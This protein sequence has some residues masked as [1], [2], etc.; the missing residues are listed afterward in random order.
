[1]KK[2]VYYATMHQVKRAGQ[3]IVNI[4]HTLTDRSY[5]FENARLQASIQQLS[6]AISNSGKLL[7]DFPRLDASVI[8]GEEGKVIYF[9]PDDSVKLN[10]LE[11]LFPHGFQDSKLTRVALWNLR[12]A[13]QQWLPETDLVVCHVSRLFPGTV[14]APIAFDN[15]IRIHQVVPLRSSLDE[16]LKGRTIRKKLN[17]HLRQDHRGWLSN[18]QNDF[19]HFYY[20]MYLPSAQRRFGPKCVV[21]PYESLLSWFRRGALLSVSLDGETVAG[22]LIQPQN[23]IWFDRYS[24]FL[25]GKPE[26]LQLG[27]SVILYWYS[28]MLAIEHGARQANFIDSNAWCSDG[29][30]EHKRSWGAVVQEDPYTIGKL[31][32]RAEKLSPTWQEKLNKIG[33]L[34]QTEQGFLYVYH[35]EDHHAPNDIHARLERAAH[36]GLQGVRLIS[37]NGYADLLIDKHNSPEALPA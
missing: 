24:G 1:M 9:G 17:R 19:D 36:M 31:L 10:V 15:P 8:S 6:M 30:F 13:M 4:G 20:R 14:P 3:G 7:V 26:I 29:V 28:L 16:L 18:A 11:T 2:H 35:Q 27:V 34:T 23:G 33:F 37:P 25:D 5:R 32:F 22:S 12:D 21:Q